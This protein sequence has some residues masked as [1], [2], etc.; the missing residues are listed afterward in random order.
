MLT[1]KRLKHI[2]DNPDAHLPEMVDMAHELLRLRQALAEPYAIIE[3]MGIN[4][5]AD[6]NAA[7]VWPA[8]YRQHQDVYLYRFDDGE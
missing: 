7:M 3:P 1:D 2:A 8:R 6:G 4:Y 5:I